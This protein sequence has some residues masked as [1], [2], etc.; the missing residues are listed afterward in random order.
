MLEQLTEMDSIEAVP[1]SMR[2]DPSRFLL[3]ASGLWKISYIY[4]VAGRHRQLGLSK[5]ESDGLIS[6]AKL[7]LSLPGFKDVYRTHTSRFRAHNR[8]FLEV[9][10][11]IYAEERS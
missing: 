6:E 7:W 5:A 11:E 4:S 9:F 1:E 2:E 3:F 8:D 10:D